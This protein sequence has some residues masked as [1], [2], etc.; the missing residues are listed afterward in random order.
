MANPTQKEKP[1][2]GNR[3]NFGKLFLPSSVERFQTNGTLAPNQ[4]LTA[5]DPS[6]HPILVNHWPWPAD[7]MERV[8]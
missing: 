6:T 4:A 5:P 1:S 7:A 2:A 3:R 8:A